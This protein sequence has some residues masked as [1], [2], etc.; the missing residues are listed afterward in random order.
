M[1]YSTSA[2]TAKTRFLPGADI[3]SGWEPAYEAFKEVLE[4]KTD[5]SF[6]K[7][8]NGVRGE[9]MNGWTVLKSG[10]GGSVVH[11]V[12]VGVNWNKAKSDDEAIA[13]GHAE[14]QKVEGQDPDGAYE[15]ETGSM[16]DFIDDASTI[17]CS[18]CRTHQSEE[19][20]ANDVDTAM[21][22]PVEH[23]EEITHDTST[24]DDDAQ[25]SVLS[26][27]QD[28][29]FQ[30]EEQAKQS[31]D[32]DD[33]PLRHT[34][35]R[36]IGSKEKVFAPTIMRDVVT[37]TA[38]EEDGDEDD[39]PLSRKR[40]RQATVQKTV[41]TENAPSTAAVAAPSGDDDK[42]DMP[43]SHKRARRDVVQKKAT[44]KNARH[45]NITSTSADEGQDEN[46]S[47]SETETE[48]ETDTQDEDGDE[49]DYQDKDN[50][51][52][53][54]K[55]ARRGTVQTEVSAKKQK[56]REVAVRTA[57]EKND[58]SL[59]RKSARKYAPRKNVAAPKKKTGKGAVR[60]AK[61]AEGSSKMS[62]RGKRASRRAA[63]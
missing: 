39:M 27:I 50:I 24:S 54:R 45:S 35:G 5:T 34:R 23:H 18:E 40:A 10:E 33:M 59:S 38:V 21:E 22:E 30:A 60:A 61:R 48:T 29:A 56:T 28:D 17:A 15:S 1:T 57:K 36:T 4:K 7:L 2:T 25:S 41:D 9:V 3:G 46:D 8:T 13:A 16:E 55:R 6:E 32:E 19:L 58:L 47:A 52:L 26:S 53:S 31:E 14:G 43:L 37:T 20:G 11:W 49:S 51:S 63:R 62:D 12:Q 44:T 42:D